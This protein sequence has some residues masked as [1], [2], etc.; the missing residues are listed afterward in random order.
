MKRMFTAMTAFLLSLMFLAVPGPVMALDECMTGSWYDPAVE[1]EGINIEVLA[2]DAAVAYF[3]TYEFFDRTEQNWVVFVGDPSQMDAFDT[4][5][6][7]D[8]QAEY[9]VGSGSIVA[10]DSDTLEFSHDFLLN[11]DLV[12]ADGPDAL[13]LPYC[14]DGQCERT[15]TYIR[16]TQPIPC[17][18]G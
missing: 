1:H 16:L 15:Y 13:I 12:G 3:Y 17:R 11:L 10:I 5:P 2:N 7:G 18:A 8:S 9:D 14:L 4:V 6:L